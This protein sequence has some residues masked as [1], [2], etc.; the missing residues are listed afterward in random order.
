MP[1]SAIWRYQREFGCSNGYNSRIRFR[2]FVCAWVWPRTFNFGRLADFITERRVDLHDLPPVNDTQ[3][4]IHGSRADRQHILLGLPFACYQLF[5]S[6]SC[7]LNHYGTLE[8]K[9][10]SEGYETTH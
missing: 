9:G 3:V 4:G 10:G 6:S 5:W 2:Q 8:R 7:L 1:P